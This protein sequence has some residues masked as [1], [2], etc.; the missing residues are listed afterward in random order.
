MA[1][2][3]TYTWNDEN[4]MVSASNAEV[5]V[6]YAYDHKGRM[7]R[8]TISRGDAE[9]Q[10]VTYIW[11]GWNIIRETHAS[12]LVSNVTYN[13]WGLDLDG[14][15]QG[16]GGVGGLLAVIRDGETYIPTYDAN[17]N[18]SEYIDSSDG[19]I[20]AHYDYSPFGETLVA[21]GPLASTFTHRFSTKP[22]CP[23]TGFC[24]Y[25]MR[26][27]RPDIGRWMS[28][29]PM[30]EEGGLNLYAACDND[31][32]LYCDVI[33]L[34]RWI[35]IYYSKPDSPEFQRAAETYKQEIENLQSFN[36]SCDEVMLK[37]V[38]T[39]QDFRDVWNEINIMVAKEEPQFLVKEIHIFSHAGQGSLY[40]YRSSL[41]SCDIEELPKLNWAV[42]GLIVCHGCNTGICTPNGDSIAKSFAL[43]QGVPT[44]G[45]TGYAQFSTIKEKRTLFTRVDENSKKVYLWSF[46]DGGK[47]YTYGDARNPAEEQP[48]QEF[49]APQDNVQTLPKG[50][51]KP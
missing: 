9:P 17:G 10:T 8:K 46:G 13:L 2:C 19:S 47:E 21:S 23:V 30:G 51:F 43:S 24:E 3:F 48:Q 39:I 31:I 41:H 38:Q 40:F 29:D 11:D 27:Y 44:Q 42:E 22:W 20:A 36:K 49:L 1:N 50:I 34:Y 45:Q 32:V 5:V 33:G 15:P 26:K 14:T 37:G 4:R 7:I 6:T 28:R 18:I 16:A 35:A 12:G 25:Q